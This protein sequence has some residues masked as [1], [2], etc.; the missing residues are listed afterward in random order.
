MDLIPATVKGRRLLFTAFVLT[1][2]LTVVLA[3][4]TVRDLVATWEIPG[5]GPE[6]DQF[7]TAT[8]EGNLESGPP[9]ALDTNAPLQPAGFPAPVD[10]DGESR[11]TVLLMG[12]DQRGEE[13][14]AAR[15]DTLILLSI[16]PQSASAGMLSI[17][18][19][20][21]VNIPGFDYGKINTANQLGEAFQVEGRGPGL[22][23][24][25]VEELIGLPVDFYAQVDFAAFE[26]II[27]ELGGVKIDVPESI[28]VDPIGDPPPKTL[29]PGIQT[30]PGALALAYARARNTPGGDFDRAARQQQVLLAVK[31]RVFSFDLIPTLVA[32]A[33]VLYQE[34]ASGI[35]TNLTGE[36]IIRLGFIA[37]QISFENI[38]RAVITEEYVTVTFS[39]DGQYILIP[40]P[41]KIRQ[42]RDQVFN[43]TTEVQPVVETRPLGDLVTAEAATIAV[44]NGTYTSGLAAGT[45]EYLLA[46]G[47]IVTQTDNAEEVF[48]RTT[49]TDFT[50]NPYTLQYLVELLKIDPGYIFNSFD[51]ESPVDIQIVL[52]ED[53]AAV[54]GIP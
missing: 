39:F 19:D 13:D 12:S 27:D 51:P 11:I 16:D 30:L 45:T 35:R 29:Q 49:I 41:D 18:R 9:L 38:H 2:G 37:Q 5:L 1:A 24:A 10:W 32:R 26:R 14:R 15:T 4:S 31:D 40:I 7:A 33:P 3:Y 22:A 20:T 17:P 44:L 25:V 53:W 34:L 6:V 42:L 47:L 43:Y 8:A 23:M 28:L 50:G 48:P 54:G 46:F 36:Q 52:G 21:W